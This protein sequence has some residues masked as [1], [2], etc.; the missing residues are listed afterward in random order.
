MQPIIATLPLIAT[1]SLPTPLRRAD[2]TFFCG[3]MTCELAHLFQEM[4]LL[5][6][7]VA[8]PDGFVI[9]KG[10][11]ITPPAERQTQ[12][13]YVVP[14]HQ[15]QRAT[16]C[17]KLTPELLQA[18]AE[19]AGGL[20][21]TTFTADT[22]PDICAVLLSRCVDNTWSVEVSPQQST[23]SFRRDWKVGTL[24]GDVLSGAMAYLQVPI[25]PAQLQAQ[26]SKL[27]RPCAA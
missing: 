14:D 5:P 20:Y 22:A 21:G 23:C 6:P 13:G 15:K 27:C 18:W 11:M 12:N 8:V 10:I 3:H 2:Y 16:L 7:G 17:V 4:Q 19:F 1:S 26:F 25:E 9:V 24:D